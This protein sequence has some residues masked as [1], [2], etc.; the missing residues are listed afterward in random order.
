MRGMGL[1][2]SGVTLAQL[3]LLLHLQIEEQTTISDLAK[4]MRTERTTLN[5]N[6]KPWAD[7][8]LIAINPGQDSRTREI[9][10]T[11]TGRDSVAKG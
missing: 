9:M 8:G 10:L 5:R 7:D 4:I 2:P 3:A 6:M 1:K 11:K